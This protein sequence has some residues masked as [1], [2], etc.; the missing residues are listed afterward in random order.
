M[1]RKYGQL[2]RKFHSFLWA[3][4]AFISFF[5]IF[6]DRLM[7]A[8]G[9]KN[10]YT[11]ANNLIK[12]SLNW[13]IVDLRESLNKTGIYFSNMLY[14]IVSVDNY[15][16]LLAIFLLLVLLVFDN[17]LFHFLFVYFRFLFIHNFEFISSLLA[18]FW[19]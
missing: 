2:F 3:D 14:D 4:W 6:K 5:I 15:G 1:T 18:L 10:S 16:F 12:N 13:Y 17:I 7:T 8:V 9:F 11:E 19:L